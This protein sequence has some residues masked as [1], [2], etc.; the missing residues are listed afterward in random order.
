VQCTSGCGLEDEHTLILPL[1]LL[2]SEEQLTYSFFITT[3]LFRDFTS[4]IEQICRGGAFRS[5]QAANYPTL[6]T[7]VQAQTLVSGHPGFGTASRLWRHR[8]I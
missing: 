2:V 5:R 8:A 3:M 7:L 6:L 4:Y 1:L